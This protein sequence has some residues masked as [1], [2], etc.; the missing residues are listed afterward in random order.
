M[1]KSLLGLFL[2]FICVAAVNAETTLVALTAADEPV[3]DGVSRRY[4]TTTGD[5]ITVQLG[6]DTRQTITVEVR[7]FSFSVS[8]A[9]GESLEAGFYDALAEG[10]EAT[11]LAGDPFLT[12]CEEETDFYRLAFQ[13]IEL[14]IEAS[15]VT[16]L[17][18]DMIQQCNTNR[19]S[20]FLSNDGVLRLFLRMNSEAESP[21]EDGDGIVDILDNCR[22]TFNA[23]QPDAD[24]DGRGDVCDEQTLQTF[25]YF[26]LPDNG[27]SFFELD[28]GTTFF[29][30][31][32]VSAYALSGT[33]VRYQADL[34][35]R[36]SFFANGGPLTE[37]G[38]FT[39]DDDA[40]VDPSVGSCTWVGQMLVTEVVESG[41]GALAVDFSHECEAREG[42]MLGEIRFH[43]T[44]LGS[45]AVDAD[46][47]GFADELDNCP[48]VANDQ[49]DSDAD[50]IG[51][52]CDRY[53]DNTENVA[54]CIAEVEEREAESMQALADRATL[55]RMLR[56][57]E[58]EREEI[59][60]ETMTLERQITQIDDEDLDGVLDSADACPGSADGVT[61]D[62]D[63]CSMDQF[64]GEVPTE[65]LFGIRNC[66]L[67]IYEPTVMACQATYDTQ[68]GRFSC[69]G[70]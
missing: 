17:A 54:S 25:A 26:D 58:A 22:T 33:E 9:P 43:S 61:V 19:N 1:K 30:D 48:Q 8:S 68:L 44:V 56:T 32:D 13:I 41:A 34:D 7:D 49:T 67:T 42:L 4:T 39:S 23:L 3:L 55:S 6:E 53:P 21:D 29:D 36:I 24:F 52:A 51:D 20:L 57:I 50:G 69:S 14:E 31:R 63:G 10:V 35:D 70:G 37:P 65:N 64:C 28:G 59:E 15:A 11:A 46:Q 66:G 18:L 12:G 40:L 16:K 5:L 47:D 62:D 27:I 38:S 60:M 45:T 2:A